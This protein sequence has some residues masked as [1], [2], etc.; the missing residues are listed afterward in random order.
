MFSGTVNYTGQVARTTPG[1]PATGPGAVNLGV[2]ASSFGT[3]ASATAFSTA[4]RYTGNYYGLNLGSGGIAA[5][6]AGFTFGGNIIG[7]DDNGQLSERPKGGAPLLGVIA[8]V[9]YVKGPFTIGI[10]GEEYWEQGNVQLTGISQRRARG[11]STGFAYAIA[12]GFTAYAEYQWVD[13]TQNG[14]NFVTGAVGSNA[15]NNVRG[16]GFLV[17]NVVNF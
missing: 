13:Q 3:G 2:A 7:G 1:G 17:G 12:P 10:T 4:S 16:Q 11:L 14:L 6:Y 9:K 5:T 8:G 15:N